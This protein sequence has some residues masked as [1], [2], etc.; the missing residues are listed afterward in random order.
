LGDPY[1]QY[2]PIGVTVFLA[3]ALAGVFYSK[4]DFLDGLMQKK[5]DNKGKLEK[6]KTMKIS[7]N[8]S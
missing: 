6:L 5:S 1:R 2:L 4:H 7:K 8:E 3:I